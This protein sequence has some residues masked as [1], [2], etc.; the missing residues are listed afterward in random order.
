MC[1]LNTTGLLSCLWDKQHLSSGRAFRV[2]LR[3]QVLIFTPRPR[4]IPVLVSWN[5][6]WP[7]VFAH[8]SLHYLER[9]RTKISI[10]KNPHNTGRSGIYIIHID[11]YRYTKIQS[12]K[13]VN[14]REALAQ[15]CEVAYS[16]VLEWHRHLHLHELECGPMPNVMAALP[17]I[18]GAL[19]STPQSL[20]DAHY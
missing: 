2:K 3:E 13:I 15:D 20:A 11:T 14:E 8:S 16:C 10:E 9:I 1:I 12:T 19:C 6:R 17:N 7:W 18:G 4:Y 5:R